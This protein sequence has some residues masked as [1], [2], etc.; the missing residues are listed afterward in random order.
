[1]HKMYHHWRHFIVLLNKNFKSLFRN[2]AL[3]R[4]SLLSP[5]LIVAIFAVTMQFNTDQNVYDI[6]FYNQDKIDILKPAEDFAARASLDY[7]WAAISLNY[8][9][10]YRSVSRSEKHIHPAMHHNHNLHI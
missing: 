5:V 6:G 1:M 9:C 10:N 3:L 2:R 8:V 4:L 7:I